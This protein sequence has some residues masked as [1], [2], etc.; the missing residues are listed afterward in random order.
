MPHEK[1]FDDRA[2]P[3]SDPPPRRPRVSRVA[4]VTQAELYDAIDDVKSSFA[5]EIP[6]LIQS[7][8]RQAIEIS[9]APV[10][11]KID[12]SD[13]ELAKQ[14][15]IRETEERLKKE[16]LEEEE[17]AMRK[18]AHRIKVDS[19]TE[20]KLAAERERVAALVPKPPPAP[21]VDEHHEKREDTRLKWS[22]ILGLLGVV[23]TLASLALGSQMHAEGHHA[24]LPPMNVG[25]HH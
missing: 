5:K 19:W 10:M 1:P 22:I 24:E 18:E 8:V 6:G 23:V 4:F 20:E 25:E 7:S 13:R 9:L 2:E 3:E 14:K 12:R 11:G 21:I 17:R 15:L 16:A